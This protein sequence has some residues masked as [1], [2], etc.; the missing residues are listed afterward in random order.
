MASKRVT[1]RSVDALQCPPGK[2]RVFLWDSDLSGFGVAAMPSRKDADGRKIEGTK[3]YVVQYRQQKRSRRMKLGEHGRLTPDEARSLAKEVLGAVERGKDPIEERRARQKVRTF[4]E[5][6]EDFM[7]LH[8]AA[9][10]KD[11][12][13]E[14]YGRLLRLHLYP[15]L[16]GR[17]ITSIAKTDIARLHN[18]LSDRPSAANRCLALFDTVWNWAVGK[19]EIAGVT[20]TKGLERNPEHNRERYLTGDELR[21]LGKA[22]RDAE[23]TGVP[24]IVN[25]TGP[26]AKHLPKLKRATVV[27]PYA[28][29]AIRLLMLTGARLREI[30]NAR[31]DYIDLER[32]MMFLPDS[33][34]GRKTLYLSDIALN[35]L[36]D[37][38]H[39]K[40]NPY[41]IPGSK[42]GEP[43]A[44]LKRPWAAIARAAG[45][46]KPVEKPDPKVKPGEQ[47]KRKRISQ[48]QPS[49][50]LHD[51]RHTFAA[52]GA[53]S[54]L[55]LPVIG[56]LLGHSQARTTQRYAHLDADPMHKAANL[57]GSQIAAA[58]A[59]P[60]I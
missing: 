9:K 38:P 32:G 58:L 60:K 23:T 49:I 45:L 54:S 40:G 46:L 51:L 31:W 16:G 56:K 37:L 48:E 4:K 47:K 34:T 33:K 10:K 7:R 2:D 5:V 44:D 43:R 39:L 26:K 14:E 35:L 15:A 25:E 30:L 50:R 41:I 11:R 22:L 20:P 59:P 42:K 55:G 3:I 28:V 24:W 53:G 27:D 52:T 29:A 57:I 13:H 21:S 17:P 8:V 6:A 36:D 19:G 12:T 1:K 18:S